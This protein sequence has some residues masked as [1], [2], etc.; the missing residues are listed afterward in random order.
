[1]VR[2][3]AVTTAGYQGTPEPNQWFGGPELTTSAPLFG[4]IITIKEGSMVLRDASGLVVDSLN[5]GGLVDP[6]AAEGY[7]A[8]SGLRQS[9]C[10]A[11][12]P[13]PARRL[14]SGGSG[15]NHQFKRGPL[16]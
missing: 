13:G 9:G 6:W 5:Y 14:W 1:M 12:A 16:P 7:Q 10:F 3:A 15:C 2:D 11:P 8:A 4:R